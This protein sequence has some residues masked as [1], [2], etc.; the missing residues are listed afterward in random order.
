MFDNIMVVHLIDRGKGKTLRNHSYCV[1]N[2]QT[3]THKVISDFM[4]VGRNTSWC[5][6]CWR[7]DR[8]NILYCCSHLTACNFLLYLI[9]CTLIDNDRR[10]RFLT[11]VTDGHCL[12]HWIIWISNLGI[13]MRFLL[14]IFAHCMV[15]YD[16]ISSFTYWN[17]VNTHAFCLH[18]LSF[19]W[20]GRGTSIKRWNQQK[21]DDGKCQL[22]LYTRIYVVCVILLIDKLV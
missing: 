13:K 17:N 21:E 19:S 6:V 11:A 8:D 15:K 5:C 3:N 1:N 2:C 20:L 10:Q 4:W 22:P 14:Y 16:G 12:S 7:I 9:K 18:Y